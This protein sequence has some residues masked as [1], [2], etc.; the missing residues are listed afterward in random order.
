VLV[1]VAGWAPVSGLMPFGYQAYSTVADRYACL[2]ALGAALALGDLISRLAPETESPTK[3]P[4][5]AARIVACVWILIF[6]ALAWAQTAVWRNSLTVWEKTL[7]YN[8]HPAAAVLANYGSALFHAGRDEDALRVLEQCVR[9]KPQYAIGHYNLG[10][11]YQDMGRFEEARAEY[12]DALKRYPA[13]VNSWAALGSVEGE[14]KDYAGC[15]EAS[16]KA[17]RLD[18]GNAV[19]VYNLQV[20]IQK[21]NPGEAVAALEAAV[22]AN[23][24]DYVAKFYLAVALEKAGRRQE[25]RAGFLQV[26]DVA[27]DK[28]PPALREAAVNRVKELSKTGP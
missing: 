19:A 26:A 21:A 13:H 18:S 6:A 20:A 8:H 27:E 12:L 5:T 1:F 14:M 16:L 22:S 11:V 4:A 25:A 2:P 28:I 10:C 7:E 15:V 23:P 3:W 9:E 24:E 17:L